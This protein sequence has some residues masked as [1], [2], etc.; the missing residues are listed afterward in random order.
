ML[1]FVAAYHLTNVYF[2]KQVAFE[3]FILLDGGVYTAVF[4]L[5]YVALGS[6]VPLA[7][8]YAR[9]AGE[10]AALIASAL[11]VAGGFCWLYVFIVGGQ[12]FPLELF[13]GATVTSTFFDGA[14]A[15]YAPSVPELLLGVGGLAAAFLVTIVGVRVLDFMPRDPLTTVAD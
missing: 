9:V 13:P 15:S 7:L 8:I 12:A 11:V 3:R 10:R 1:Y 4:W 14:V 2:A 6:V 5:G